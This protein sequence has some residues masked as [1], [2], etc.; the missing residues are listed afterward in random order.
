MTKQAKGNESST[1]RS[2]ALSF[3]TFLSRILGLVRDHFMAVSFGTGMVASAFSVAYRLPNMFRNL[4]AEGTLSQSF[5]PIF[6]EYEKIGVL[7]ARVM[8]GTVLSFL[9]LCLSLFVALFWFFAAG[10]LPALVGG[11]PEYGTLVVE[12]SLVLF[13]LIMTASLSSIFMSISNS[14]HNYFVPSL[15]PI[16]LNFS[17]L[18]VFIFVFPFYHE[19]REKVFVLAYGIVTGG[20]LQL[21]V[22]TWYV[23]R[24]GYGP[25]FHLNLKHPAIR[26]I[27]KLMLPAALGGSFYQIGLLVDIFLAN[28]IQNQNP[29][30][31]AVVSLDYSQRLVQLPTGI[32][33]VAL[34][35]TILPSLL[36]DLREGREDN[37]PKEISDVLAFAFFLTLPASIGLAVLGETVLDSIYF[38]GRWDHLATITAFY[39]LVFYSFAIPFYSINKVLVSSYYAFSDTKTPLRIQLVSFILSVLVSIGLMF[40]LKHSAIALASALSA[41]VTSTLLLYYLKSHQV[42]I[43]FLVVWFRI[44]KMVP[45]LFGLFLWLVFS[46]WVVKPILVTYLSDSLGLGFANVSRICLV[47][48]ILPAVIIYFVVAGIT[49]LPEAEIIL[50]RFFRKVRKIS[51]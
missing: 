36:K 30:L 4:L 51:S 13:F 25:I 41:S 22:Q 21:L 16:I 1:R 24:N 38:G 26:K 5:M 35:T 27:F 20:V 9:F 18:I 44:L 37:V 48:S 8:A 39:P 32:I 23:Y 47:V 15:S 11:T 12:L 14:H 3:Y 42:K 19:I 31:G 43:P 10:F 34:A 45:A 17:Y 40:F 2:L 46:E 7:E 6:S 29:G 33:G 49:K 28:Y 50:G